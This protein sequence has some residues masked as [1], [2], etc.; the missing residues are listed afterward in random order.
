MTASNQPTVEDLMRWRSNKNSN[1]MLALCNTCGA[2]RQAK[3][4]RNRDYERNT[5]QLKC[6]RCGKV[7]VHALIRGNS[8]DEQ[9]HAFAL[10]MPDAYGEY[11][12]PAQMDRWRNGM[13]RN[14]RLSHIWMASIER[15]AIEAREPK[16]RAL[17][18]ELV[19]TPKRAEDTSDV[20]LQDRKPPEYSDR[21]WNRT[22]DNG[23]QY[24][25]CVNCVRV[26]NHMET[27][28][29]RDTLRKLMTT[30][31]A[32]LLDKPRAA[33]YDQHSQRLI[34][35]LRAVHGENG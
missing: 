18:G 25:E 16:M 1:S 12:T 7:T 3:R 20:P 17:C 30:A 27:V 9:A 23:W 22:D 6:I 19:T 2:V 10:G 11:A 15:K 24:M 14:P 21:D 32:E 34:D 28:R 5:G 29:R 8:W 13:P 35:L 31:L 33:I 4:P 26:H